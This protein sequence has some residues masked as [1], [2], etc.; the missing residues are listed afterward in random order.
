MQKR[1]FIW[2]TRNTDIDN[3]CN[4]MEECDSTA[5]IF[6][7]FRPHNLVRIKEIFSDHKIQRY[8]DQND[9][10][11]VE[12]KDYSLDAFAADA[13]KFNAD[14]MYNAPNGKLYYVP[15]DAT[16][17]LRNF[18]RSSPAMLNN[19]STRKKLN[20]LLALNQDCYISQKVQENRDE[21]LE[22]NSD[23][24][25]A[26]LNLQIPS[27]FWDDEKR[28]IR[29]ITAEIAKIPNIKPALENFHVL[30]PVRQKKLFKSVSE[31]TAKYNHITLPH[32]FLL[33]NEEVKAFAHADW[34]DADAFAFEKNIYINTDK[35]KELNGIQCLS[36]AWHETNHI[37]QSYGDYRKYPMME[38]MFNHRLNYLN[39]YADVYIMHPQEKVTYALEKLFLEESVA[40]IG[41]IPDKQMFLPRSEYNVATQYMAKA[42]QRKF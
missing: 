34:V 6:K 11:Y 3:E 41:L 25:N 30:S 15:V 10:H 39:E 21:F 8:K 32:L 35:M 1:D 28:K 40:R 17:Y 31:I 12:I 38:D 37:A 13:Q 26:L 5:V 29:L 33:N 19:L 2:L 18:R 7:I 24:L 9:F 42:M 27:V 4:S 22:Y 14:I 16:A 23:K 20:M 36:L